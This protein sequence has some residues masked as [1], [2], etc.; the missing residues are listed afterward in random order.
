MEKKTIYLLKADEGK[1]IHQISKDLYSVS[2]LLS[3]NDSLDDFEEVD[4]PVEPE[5]DEA[6]TTD[7]DSI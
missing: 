1:V 7:S 5:E 3:E 6:Q 2:I 4:P